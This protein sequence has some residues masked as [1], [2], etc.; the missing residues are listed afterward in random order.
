MQLGIHLQLLSRLPMTKIPSPSTLA[1][2]ASLAHPLVSASLSGPECLGKI[3]GAPSFELPPV[4]NQKE[5]GVQREAHR[6][7]L[8]V[9]LC[10]VKQGSGSGLPQGR[11]QPRGFSLG[12]INP[13]VTLGQSKTG[14]LSPK[15]TK[16]RENENKRGIRCFSE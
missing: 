15:R 10:K 7:P 6:K 8:R 14:T 4:W 11:L 13:W 5:G 16:K 9:P 3:S 12:K 1:T 2:L